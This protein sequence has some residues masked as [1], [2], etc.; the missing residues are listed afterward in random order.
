[1][2]NDLWD[3]IKSIFALIIL[4]VI[5]IPFLWGLDFD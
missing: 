5:I 2:L 3:L 4:V 1:M